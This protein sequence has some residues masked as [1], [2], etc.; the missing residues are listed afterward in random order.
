M[1]EP[2]KWKETDY[3]GSFSIED[4]SFILAPGMPGQNTAPEIRDFLQAMVDA[5][6]K[7]G[8]KPSG[9]IDSASE[10]KAVRAHLEDMRQIA[11]QRA[12]V[13]LSPP[14]EYSDT[15]RGEGSPVREE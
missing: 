2:L 4:G 10:L 8:I 6:W 9:A 1:A 14:P 12:P 5:A 15:W 11:I 3:A 13:V 7:L